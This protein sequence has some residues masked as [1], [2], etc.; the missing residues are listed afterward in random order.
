MGLLNVPSVKL[1]LDCFLKVM[2][3]SDLPKYYAQDVAP[4]SGPLQFDFVKDGTTRCAGCAI[5]SNAVYSICLGH[6]PQP[7]LA[8]AS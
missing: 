3:V 4:R 5:N 7:A 1:V 6:G 2:Q 8:A